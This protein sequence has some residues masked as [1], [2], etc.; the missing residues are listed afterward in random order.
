MLSEMLPLGGY[1]TPYLYFVYILWLPFSITRTQ[2]L[3]V[4]MLYGLCYSYLI[5]SPGIQAAACVLIAYI[6]PFLLSL[7]LPK[8]VKEMNYAEPSIKSMGFVPYAVYAVTLTF[9]HHSYL[10]LLQWFSVGNFGYFFI[11][12]ILT[13]IV[14]IVLI[15]ILEMLISRNRKTRA[16]LK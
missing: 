3:L 7:L 11:K 1:V 9:L 15:G 8:E 4:S 6:R 10:V 16:S 2:L 13:T 5:L 12:V 14:S